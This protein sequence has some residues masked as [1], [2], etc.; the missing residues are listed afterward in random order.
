MSAGE[1]VPFIF[2]FCRPRTVSIQFLQVILIQ[3][4][5]LYTQKETSLIAQTLPP[6]PFCK[7]EKFIIGEFVHF[8]LA[9]GRDDV[10]ELI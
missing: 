6:Q 7:K 3:P 5:V 2:Q 1:M 9:L 8:R 4:T 10:S